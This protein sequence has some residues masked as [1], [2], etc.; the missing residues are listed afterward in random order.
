MKKFNVEEAKALAKQLGVDFQKV[1][2]LQKN[3]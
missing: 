2:L 1:S 3:S